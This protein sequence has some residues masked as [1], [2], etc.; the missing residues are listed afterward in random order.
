[1]AEEN[2]YVRRSCRRRRWRDF[3]RVRGSKEIE[4]NFKK[5]LGLA[6]VA[7]RDLPRRRQVV[8]RNGVEESIRLKEKSNIRRRHDWKIFGARNVSV[9]EGVPE[10]QIA[11]GNRT[12]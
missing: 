4:R 6:A 9:A 12:I 1:M 8:G 11:V 3:Q 7:A 10:N 5:F 2:F